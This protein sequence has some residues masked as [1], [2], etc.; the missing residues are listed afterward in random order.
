MT[1][2]GSE[3]KALVHQTHQQN[4]K[5]ENKI[6]ITRQV[7]VRDSSRLRSDATALPA[8]PEPPPSSS[9]VSKQK[10]QKIARTVTI[11]LAVNLAIF[12]ACLDLTIVATAIPK[13]TDEFHS[14]SEAGWYGSAYFITIAAF[15]ATWGKLY[16]Y[17][18]M[19]WVFVAAMGLFEVGSLV[20]GV[21]PSSAILIFGRSVAGIGGAGIASGC[22]TIL[23]FAVE[24]ELVPVATGCLGAVYAVASVLGPLLGGIFTDHVTWRWCFYINLPLGGVSALII[25]FTFEPPASADPQPAS[26]REKLLQLDPLGSALIV[27]CMTSLLLA[28][29]WAGLTKAWSSGKVIGTL[30]T[31][32]GVLLLFVAN[33]YKMGERAL[34]VPRLLK[35]KTFT[36]ASAYML[37]NSAAFFILIYYLPYYFQ[38]V[39]GLSA[40]QSGVRNLPFVLSV[41]IFSILSGASVTITGH[42]TS[43]Q[44]LGSV[45]II[46]AA[47]LIWTLDVGSGAGKWIGF[48]VLAG[49]GTGFSFQLPVVVSQRTAVTEEVSTVSAICLFF[50]CMAGGIFISASQSVFANGLIGAVK[51]NV[52]GLPP[53]LVLA[54]GA[55]N[56]RRYFAENQVEGIVRSYMTGLK[57]AFAFS[58]AL[59]GVGLLIAVLNLTWDNRNLKQGMPSREVEN[60]VVEETKDG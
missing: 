11:L 21:A 27:C 14:L 32:G 49:I 28:L 23:A 36:L 9:L 22:Y 37:F 42:Y 53:Q 51:E 44:L 3:D 57:N 8:L 10:W 16:K 55:T 56:I 45:L 60:E 52:P 29:Q 54:A 43:N 35:Q 41:S 33:E 30:V 39:H 31:F 34:L 5:S 18:P 15:Q 12:L 38:S 25:I 7:S 4:G 24:P 48:Q 19:K 6:T 46:V 47:G 17:F 58:I 2:T 40:S 13:I 20:C 59:A 26:A 1:S 50:Q